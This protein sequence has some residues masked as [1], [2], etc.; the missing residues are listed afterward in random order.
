MFDKEL[1]GRLYQEA[2]MFKPVNLG[3]LYHSMGVTNVAGFTARQLNRKGVAVDVALVE[4]GGMLHDIGKMFDGTPRGHT[5]E[6]VAFLKRQGVDERIIRL[7]QRHQVWVFQPGEI[8][9]PDSWE[10]KLVFLGDMAFQ[11]SI[12][13]VKERVADLLERYA[14]YMPETRKKWLQEKSQEIY[15][16]ISEIISPQILP[17]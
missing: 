10:E 6:G 15:R 4:N 13:S 8:P 9:D 2:G 1:V 5:V 14:R 7:V 11:D 16:E 3:I 17:F 12:V